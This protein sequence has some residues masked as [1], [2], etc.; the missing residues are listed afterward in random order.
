MDPVETLTKYK[1]AALC[2][3]K[4]YRKHNSYFQVFK[5]AR[6]NIIMTII[7]HF[8]QL[9]P[10]DTYTLD[11]HALISSYKIYIFKLRNQLLSFKLVDV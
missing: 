1:P 5:H 7:F 4:E 6:E 11:V 9:I 3:Y 10:P 2:R 8:R